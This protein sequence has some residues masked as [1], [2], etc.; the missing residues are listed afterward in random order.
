MSLNVSQENNR[1]SFNWL[2]E[3][4][5]S[6]D[7][8]NASAYAF[9]CGEIHAAYMMNVITREQYETLEQAVDKKFYEVHVD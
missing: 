5:A 8:R 4:V 6:L 2:T 1:I 3:K 7:A 9:T